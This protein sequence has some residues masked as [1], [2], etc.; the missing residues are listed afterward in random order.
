MK[1]IY[2]GGNFEF[3][4]KNYSI[5][6]LAKDYRVEI[7]G[8]VDKILHTP[9]NET[10]TVKLGGNLYY[11]GPYYFYEEGTGAASIVAN[12]ASFVEK[13]TDAI[14]LIDNTNIPGTIT[15]IVHA[16][17]LKKRI[18]IFYVKQ[19]LDEGEPENEICSANWYPLEFAK[20]KANAHLVECE[21]REMA[22]E[23]IYNYV[24]S[25]K[26]S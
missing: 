24:N 26:K 22:K 7:L 16:A 8:D 3:Q 17:T 1:I 4:Y 12:E 25:L 15:E 21:N 5:N 9:K 14:F 6:K 20:L 2:F 13:C 23:L 10:T 19:P 11:C 18:A